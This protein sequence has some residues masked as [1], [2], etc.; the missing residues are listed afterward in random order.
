MK[1]TFLIAAAFVAILLSSCNEAPYINAPGDNSQ[2]YPEIPTF[3][4]DTNG[5]VISVD[6]AYELGLTFKD[7]EKSTT[8]YKISG[9][10]KNL[11]TT[12]EDISSGKYTSITFDISDGGEHVI[13]AYRTNNI[14]NKPYRDPAELPAVGSQVTVQ[15]YLTLYTNSS[16]G[17]KIVELTDSYIVRITPP[18]TPPAED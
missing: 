3:H 15:G 9:E 13:Q 7:D 17:K 8:P 6:A 10:L 4:P 16:T 14:D 1:K 12:A 11:V 18:T 2:N 5:T